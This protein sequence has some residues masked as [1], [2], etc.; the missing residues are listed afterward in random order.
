MIFYHK[1]VQANMKI[2]KNNRRK[3]S[4]QSGITLIALVVTIVVLLILAGVSINALFGKSG[5][6]QKAQDTQN[7][8]NQAQMNDLTGINKLNNWIENSI[9]TTDQNLTLVKSWTCSNG[10]E[11]SDQILAGEKVNGDIVANL[12]TTGDKMNLTE[13]ISLDLYKLVIEGNG[14][15]G[16]IATFDENNEIQTEHVWLKN[17]KETNELFTKFK[18]GELDL[19]TVDFS[20]ISDGALIEEVEIKEGVTNV[21]EGAFYGCGNLKNIQMANSISD[22]GGRA[23]VATSFTS[24]RIPSNLKTIKQSTFLSTSLTSIEIPENVTTI[25]KQAFLWSHLEKITIGKNV[26]TI[27]DTAIGTGNSEL[28]VVK[29]L[30]EDYENCEI[31]ST[32]FGYEDGLDD[33]WLSEGSIVYVL[34]EGMKNKLTGTYDSTKT[35]IKI[36]T[37]EEMNAI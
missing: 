27:G 1:K 20:Q 8:M 37:S 30:I 26:K 31:S 16:T 32:C 2:K 18:A 29:I 23:F 34:N 12:Y 25:E 11:W 5:I 36:V 13:E 28:K 24:I 6:I 33:D 4:E 19:S 22:I 7:K 17:M 21:P 10:G 15:M 9:G 3:C 35:E 14:K